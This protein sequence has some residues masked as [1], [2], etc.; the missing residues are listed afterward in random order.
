LYGSK[1]DFVSSLNAFARSTHKV[2]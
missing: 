2:T 1:Q